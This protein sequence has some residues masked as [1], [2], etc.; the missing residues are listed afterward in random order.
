MYCIYCWDHG[1]V[2]NFWWR[3]ICNKQPPQRLGY[4]ETEGS[5]LNQRLCVPASTWSLISTYST[6]KLPDSLKYCVWIS[7]CS[8]S[9][10]KIPKSKWLP[11]LWFE[12][13]KC[14]SSDKKQERVIAGKRVLPPS[15]LSIGLRNASNPKFPVLV[16]GWRVVY[17]PFFF[18]FFFIIISF[19]ATEQCPH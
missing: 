18:M 11:L 14:K 12:C 19:R 2:P 5:L 17:F 15:S 10:L 6:L 13:T 16:W 8:K 3:V 9:I 7:T 4:P 1:A